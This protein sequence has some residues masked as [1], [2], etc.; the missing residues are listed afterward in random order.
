MQ[1]KP[2]FINCKKPILCP[3]FSHIPAATT[4][5]LA[6]IIVPLPPRH[7]PN[8]SAQRTGLTGKLV[9][10]SDNFKT[11]GIMAVAYGI[12]SMKADTIPETQTSKVMATNNLK[13]PA[14]TNEIVYDVHVPMKSINP[15]LVNPS[16]RMKR[17]PKNKRVVHSTFSTTSSRSSIPESN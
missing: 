16:I 6:P 17:E 9:G 14:G 12:L 10:S 4:F 3:L 5:A 8:A 11:T 7:V 13:S 15:S 1:G 2:S